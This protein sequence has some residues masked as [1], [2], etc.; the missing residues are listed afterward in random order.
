MSINPDK[1]GKMKKT[2][3]WLAKKSNKELIDLYKSTLNSLH[4]F[5][6]SPANRK[7]E[8][9]KFIEIRQEFDRRQLKKPNVK[10]KFPDIPND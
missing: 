7:R 8:I 2:N 1:D 3:T 9:K 5:G 10:I 6:L 4:G